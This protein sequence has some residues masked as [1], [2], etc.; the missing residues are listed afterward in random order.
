MHKTIISLILLMTLLFP[1]FAAEPDAIRE[2]APERYTVQRGD[3][4]WSISGKFLK[5]PWKWPELWK[6]NQEQVKNPHRIYPGDVIV[7]DRAAQRL[8]IAQPGAAGQAQPGGTVRLSPRLRAQPIPD[9]AIPPI[10]PS[11]IEPFLSR[12]LVVGQNEL[13]RLPFILATQENRVA[14]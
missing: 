3:T 13:D 5:D 11:S 4:L 9:A 1:A 14:I 8:T 10:S 7:L 2:D 6:M 12:P